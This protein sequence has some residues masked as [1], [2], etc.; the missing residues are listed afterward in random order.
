MTNYIVQLIQ[1]RLHVLRKS[2][3]LN[4]KRAKSDE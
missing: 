4:S 1:K 3:T 2:Q